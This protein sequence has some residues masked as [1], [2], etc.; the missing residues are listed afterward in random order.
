MP[1][2]ISSTERVDRLRR[3][4]AGAGVDVKARHLVLRRQDALQDRHEALQIEQLVERRRDVARLQPVD[5]RR[6]EVDAADDDVARLLAGL[7][8]DLGEDC[9]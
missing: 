5:R 3:D 6:S 2:S 7:L 1:A 8:E 9:R 4:G